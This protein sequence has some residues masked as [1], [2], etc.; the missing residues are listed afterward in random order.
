MDGKCLAMA[1]LILLAIFVF[2]RIQSPSERKQ[3]SIYS[4]S[5]ECQSRCHR[6]CPDLTD[7]CEIERRRCYVNEC[8]NG[9]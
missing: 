8:K 6:A 7:E 9:F 3:G 5:S 1:V 2:M 4:F